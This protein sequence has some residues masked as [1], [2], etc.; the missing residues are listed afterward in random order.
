MHAAT[1]IGTAAVGGGRDRVHRAC[2]AVAGS[3]PASTRWE[4]EVQSLCPH[5]ASSQSNLAAGGDPVEFQFVWSAADGE[6]DRRVTADPVPDASPQERLARCLSLAPALLPSQARHL[7]RLLQDQARCACRYGGWI[8]SRWRGDAFGR[9]LYVEIP[10]GVNWEAWSSVGPAE[11]DH[12]PVRGLV[13][14][15]AGLDPARPGIE[16]YGEI[17]PMPCDA[18]VILCAQL[19]LPPVARDAVRLLEALMQQRLSAHM[20]AADQ[21]LSL[22]LDDQRRVISLTWHAHADALLGPP[23]EA[24]EALL[25]LGEA[26]GWHMNEYAALSAPDE[27]GAV[28]WH[29]VVGLTIA[30]DAAPRLSVTCSTRTEDES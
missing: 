3:P 5:P 21:G 11:L 7:E 18:L 14:I 24:R 2:L 25:A 15:M 20:P 16:L 17:A 22:A 28:P 29:G 27:Q 30:H 10:A 26:R 9:K 19:G 13:P 6:V 4:A 23:R 12:L 8:G 1:S